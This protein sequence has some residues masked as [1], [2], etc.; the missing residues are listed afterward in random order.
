MLR[1]LWEIS[2]ASEA[3]TTI[4]KAETLEETTIDEFLHKLPGSLQL[5]RK[6]QSSLHS[7]FAPTCN[8]VY[9]LINFHLHVQEN[10]RPERLSY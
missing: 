1:D 4:W 6:K 8:R 7:A 10:P 2:L 9:K 3:N 5:L